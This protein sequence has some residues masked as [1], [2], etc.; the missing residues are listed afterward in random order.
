MKIHINIER[1]DND[2]DLKKLRIY[3]E[4]NNLIYSFHGKHS[5]IEDLSIRQIDTIEHITN[6][7]LREVRR[8][9]EEI[10][11]P[12]CD[13]STVATITREI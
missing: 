8:R 6:A 11:Q 9:N 4:Y 5:W 12:I 10:C 7:I 13:P 1:C 3:D 2:P